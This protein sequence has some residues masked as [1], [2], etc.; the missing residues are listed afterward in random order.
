M[1]QKTI[2]KIVMT[3]INFIDKFII[4]PITKFIMNLTKKFSGSGKNFEKFLSKSTNLLFISLA[5]A[6]IVFI[7][8][9]L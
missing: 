6:V 8:L 5:L 7:V 9:L 2:K 1:K 3:F 4:V